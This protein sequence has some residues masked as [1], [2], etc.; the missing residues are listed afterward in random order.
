MAWKHGGST[1]TAEW[2]ST[3]GKP[4]PKRV[5]PVD[6]RLTADQAV[7][8][9][10][11]GTAMLWLGD[12]HGA[13]Q[14]LSAID[15][16]VAQGSKG[17]KGGK[18]LKR[19]SG[20]V[21]A[22]E[23]TDAEEFYRIR[24]ARAGRS[25]IMSQIL[26]PLDVNTATGM[27]EIP[28]ARAPQVGA[29]VEFGYDGWTGSGE[30]PGVEN[31]SENARRAIVSLQELVG[32][33]GAYQWFV[34][35][36]DVP[37][38]G[39]KIHPHYGTFLPTRHEYV[40]LVAEAPLAEGLQLAFDIGTGT[41]VLAAVLAKRGVAQIVG[42]DL[43]QR[44]VDCANDNFARLGVSDAAAAQLTSMFPEGRAPLVV[45]N[46]PWL[47][48]SAATTLDA[49][50]YDPGS[51]MLL[52]FLNGLPMH[53]TD[54]GEGWLIISDLAELLGLRTREMLLEAIEQAGLEIIDRLDTVPT[55]GRAS[56]AR[57][58]LHA[59]RSREVTSLWRL[60]VRVRA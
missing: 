50:V 53:L 55:H 23:L 30:K 36:V 43:H 39:A 49:A 26:V 2:L 6:D 27:A 48:G 47:P 17:S 25:R 34:N 56:D 15:R 5:V 16:R 12:F 32:V 3:S 44:A 4:A 46:P 41:G 7:K 51:K 54:G 1:H 35:G 59:A 24:Q 29:A 57:D 52:Q 40:D 21:A 31:D 37:S 18:K 60:R 19:G 20:G 42:T 9:A 45:C 11:Q 10:A 38:L 13:K 14:I 8:Y 28:L 33:Q 58:V 22:V